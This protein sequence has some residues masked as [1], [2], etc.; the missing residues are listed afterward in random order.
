MHDTAYMPTLINAD[1]GKRIEPPQ[2]AHDNMVYKAGIGY[3]TMYS[4]PGGT[5]KSG[6]PVIVEFGDYRLDPIIAH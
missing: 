6:T 5:I 2:S 4:N 3:H 1:T